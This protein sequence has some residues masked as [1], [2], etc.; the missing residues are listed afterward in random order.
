M[1]FGDGKNTFYPLVSLDVIAHEVSHG[2]T[3]V[4]FLD[5]GTPPLPSIALELVWCHVK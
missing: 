4:C 5:T 2:F 1:Y 3:N